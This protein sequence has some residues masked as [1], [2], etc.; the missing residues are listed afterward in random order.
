MD[1]KGRVIISR[2]YRG[3][4]PMSVS[5]RF[6]QYLQEND[7]MDQRPIF[8][9]EGFT[10]AYTKHNNLFLMCVTKRNSNIALLLMYL[11]RLVTAR[12]GVRTCLPCVRSYL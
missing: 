9:D 10:F 1:L 4:V 11:Y 6:V 2:N 8:T 7:E 12:L 3:D 5:E